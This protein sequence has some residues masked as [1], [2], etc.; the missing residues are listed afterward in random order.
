MLTLWRKD[1]LNSIGLLALLMHG[2]ATLPKNFERPVSHAVTDTDDTL[3]GTLHRSE[4]SAHPGQSV[5]LLLGR[6][7]DA[8][9]AR[10]VLAQAAERSIDA[11][12]FLS[13]P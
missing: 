3:I 13:V 2:C 11:Q 8:F 9:V 6:G 5:F 4:K 12:Y 7:L 10:A 1:V